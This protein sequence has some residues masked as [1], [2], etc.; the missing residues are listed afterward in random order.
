MCEVMGDA[1]RPLRSEIWGLPLED[2]LALTYAD[3]LNDQQIEFVTQGM[4]TLVGMLGEP[5]SRVRRQT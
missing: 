2:R 1:R 5:D 3:E 4:E